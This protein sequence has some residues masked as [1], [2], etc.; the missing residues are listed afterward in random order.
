MQNSIHRCLRVISLLWLGICICISIL[1]GMLQM[2]QEVFRSDVIF[3]DRYDP[4][5]YLY[6]VLSVS[7]A[8]LLKW[9]GKPRDILIIFILQMLL[10]MPLMFMF[11]CVLVY[12][13][14][15]I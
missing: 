13:F 2:R 14:K 3:F 9:Y 7:P 1:L 10:S 15:G 4:L 8:I 5:S 12:I 6:I 11:L